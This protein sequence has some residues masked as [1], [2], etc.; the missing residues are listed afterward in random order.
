MRF[1]K[2]TG[3]SWGYQGQFQL[4]SLVSGTSM[5]YATAMASS[6][7]GVWLLVGNKNHPTSSLVNSGRVNFI[8]KTATGWDYSWV[9]KTATVPTA[10]DMFGS[11]VALAP[12]STWA[13]VASSG[14]NKIESFS[15]AGD[16][17]TLRGSLPM[18]GAK[19]TISTLTTIDPEKDVLE[20]SPNGNYAYLGHRG[21]DNP[22]VAG[23]YNGAV[24]I[25]KRNG[26]AWDQEA[27]ISPSSG[28]YFGEVVKL[29]SDG[30]KLFIENR[31]S[32]D[33][34]LLIYE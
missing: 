34:D 18:S 5:S 6:M 23:T 25:W 12:D 4:H 16:V 30:I 10:G 22:N 9:L 1:W 20:L 31:R 14:A 17:W 26:N 8:K 32:N 11:V 21:Y 33:R 27:V 19:F 28:S 15:R 7:D 3:T 24:F 2:R 13:L 29:S